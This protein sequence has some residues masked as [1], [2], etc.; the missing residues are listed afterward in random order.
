[1]ARKRARWQTLKR[2]LEA[3]RPVFVDE[4]WIKT[5]MAPLRGWADR[6]ERLKGFAPH[7]S[8]AHHD[9]PRRATSQRN[10]SEGE[11]R[12]EGGGSRV[13]YYRSAAST[14]VIASIQSESTSRVS[15]SAAASALVW[16]T[17]GITPWLSP[18]AGWQH[19]SS[20]MPLGSL[21]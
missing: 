2:R 12:G 14:S 11:G 17:F 21:K 4:T 3:D 6:G 18:S 5:D 13:R 8:W 16:V 1:M 15:S 9:L 10:P 20:R 7:G 19:A